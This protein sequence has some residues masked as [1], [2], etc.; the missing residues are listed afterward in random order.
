M[1]IN[2]L[3]IH[4]FLKNDSHSMDALVRNKCEKEFIEI[5]L[6]LI[7]ALD[8]DLDIEVEAH[9]EGG[10]RDIFRFVKRKPLETG[11]LVLTALIAHL[12]VPDSEL[13]NLQKEDLRLSIE[14]RT[15]RLQENSQQENSNDVFKESLPKSSG[16]SA[17]PNENSKQDTGTNDKQDEKDQS[18]QK[19]IEQDTH[20]TKALVHRSNFY[21]NL[22]RYNKVRKLGFRLL[23][24]DNSPATDETIVQ[25]SQFPSFIVRNNKLPIEYVEDAYIEIISPVLKGNSKWRGTYIEP[26][27]IGFDMNDATFN[28]EVEGGIISFSRGDFILCSLE[29]HREISDSGNIN[30]SKY[31]VTKVIRKL[32]R[33]E[34][35]K[36]FRPEKSKK[37]Q[38]YN[39]E[40]TLFDL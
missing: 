9:A 6:E 34:V 37:R 36:N 23:S 16:D 24:D 22:T 38:K 8:L 1:D 30:I 17:S 39:T 4:Y 35:P 12:S 13:I 28:A 26:P 31:V 32:T 25:R 19:V 5:A 10:L 2:K 14:E 33:S 7:R 27:A 21:K 20:N 29:I 18:T 15:Q 11:T 40:K 3:E